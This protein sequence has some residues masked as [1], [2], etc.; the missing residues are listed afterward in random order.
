M[1]CFAGGSFPSGFFRFFELPAA[2][3]AVVLF[4]RVDFA[5]A[6]LGVADFAV[7]LLPFAEIFLAGVFAAG[8]LSGFFAVVFAAAFE[9]FF[10][11]FFAADLLL[12]LLPDEVFAAGLSATPTSER[13]NFLTLN[14]DFS[15][16]DFAAG[17]FVLSV[18]FVVL[19]ELTA[20]PL[21]CPPWIGLV[22]ANR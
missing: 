6:L 10:S 12:A 19:F 5:A 13:M 22:T 17:F 9:D 18:V 1:G 7:A 2:G 8:F 21:S 11:V 16:A 15:G 4:S 3:F 14:P 20:I